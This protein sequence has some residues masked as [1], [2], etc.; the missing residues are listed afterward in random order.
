MN[1]IVHEAEDESGVEE[2]VELRPVRL[3]DFH[4]QNERIADLKV[5]IQAARERGDALDHTLFYGGPGLGK[6]TL[7]RLIAG[8]LGVGFHGV[9]APAIQKPADLIPL[10]MSL[11]RRDVLFIDETHRLTT[12]TQEQLYTA[13][14]DFRI[15]IKVVNDD[16]LEVPHEIPIQPFTLIGA[17]TRKGMMSQPLLDRFGMT[18]MMDLYSDEDLAGII[19]RAA[20]KLGET[21]SYDQALAIARRSRGT[22]RVGLSLLKRMRDYRQIEGCAYS[23]EFIEA[24]LARLGLDEIGL[25]ALDRRYL[26][27]LKET[28]KG[29]P[30]GI[31]TLATSI[32]ES[33]E[34]LETTVEPFLVRHQLV[35][36]TRQGRIMP[37][38]DLFN[39]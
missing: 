25:N 11:K 36:R 18:F 20:P 8:E 14:E 23:V 13:M 35:A 5:F 39:P 31:D 7:A 10:L 21:L 38:P 33:R 2:T 3:E 1:D 4:G 30:V 22:P 9:A 19:Q 37:E 17:T 24:C 28:F 6:T 32:D 34:T 27:A 16:G 29:G 12:T 15:S 26:K